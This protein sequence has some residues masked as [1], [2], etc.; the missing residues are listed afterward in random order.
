MNAK[1]ARK[2]SYE[3]CTD[4]ITKIT[5][6]IKNAANDKKMSVLIEFKI[7]EPTK[8]YLINVLGYNLSGSN[9]SFFYENFKKY[10]WEI[11]WSQDKN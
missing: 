9:H 2:I 10:H 4:E 11:S 1:E 8:D 3:S 7:T 6:I 5:E